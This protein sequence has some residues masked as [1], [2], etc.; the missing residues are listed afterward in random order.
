MKAA[1]ELFDED[2]NGFI[3]APELEGALFDITAL[4]SR[5]RTRRRSFSHTMTTQTR[6]ST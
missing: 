5:R 4:T 1:F 3:E 6:S 2:G